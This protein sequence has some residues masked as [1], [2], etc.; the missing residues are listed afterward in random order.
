MASRLFKRTGV[1]LKSSKEHNQ[2]RKSKE[3]VPFHLVKQCFTRNFKNFRGFGAAAVAFFEGSLDYLFF[4]LVIHFF[5]I[6]FYSLFF[7]VQLIEHFR[8]AANP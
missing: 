7:R 4:D 3:P 5:Q 2:D 6:I 8:V 1:G